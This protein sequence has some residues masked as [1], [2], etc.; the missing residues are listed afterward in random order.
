MIGFLKKHKRAQESLLG[1]DEKN[2]Q[3]GVGA[4]LHFTASE[5]Y[6]LLRTNLNF[7]FTGEEQCRILGITSTFRGEG[8][9]LTSINLAYTL[10]Q[11]GHSVLLLEG[12]LR[13]PT[14][15]KKLEIKSKPGVVE[16]L[17]GDRLPFEQAVQPFPGKGMKFD[18]LTAGAIPP[19]PSELLGSSRMKRLLD[20]LSAHYEYIVVDLPPVSMVS[21]PLVMSKHIFGYVLV[22]RHDYCERKALRET[23]SQLQ[24]TNSKI[25]GFVY[26]S[27]NQDQGK[28]ATRYA[29]HSAYYQ[30][31]E[32]T[33]VKKGHG[34]D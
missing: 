5:A 15:A 9:T 2:G 25:L 27:A 24:Y 29:K 1:M 21:D 16:C 34:H 26:N 8:K 23:V 19:N 32:G 28:Y 6:K 14:I 4:S 18:I 13:L 22:V 3:Q 30:S 17:V 7:S 31:V 12:D 20:A 33:R 10:A 11:S